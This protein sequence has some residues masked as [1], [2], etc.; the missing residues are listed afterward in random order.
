M[1]PPNLK[2]HHKA[3]VTLSEFKWFLKNPQIRMKDVAFVLGSYDLALE[4]RDDPH[5]DVIGYF[6]TLMKHGEELQRLN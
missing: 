5:V 6:R 2:D 3:R 1:I 4:N